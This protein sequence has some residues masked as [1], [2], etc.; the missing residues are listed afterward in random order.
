MRDAGWF[1][2]AFQFSARPDYRPLTPEN[3]RAQL[4]VMIPFP[5]FVSP[6]AGRSGQVTAEVQSF[7]NTRSVASRYSFVMPSLPAELRLPMTVPNSA[8]SSSRESLPTRAKQR[9]RFRSP[10]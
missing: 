4:F 7:Y 5:L 1:P 3:A 9:G 6:Q 2:A 8:R 10:P